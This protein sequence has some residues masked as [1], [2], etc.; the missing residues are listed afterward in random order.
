MSRISRITAAEG[1]KLVQA[2]ADTETALSNRMQESGHETAEVDTAMDALIKWWEDAHATQVGFTATGGYSTADGR[3]AAH[4]TKT[5][6]LAITNRQAAYRE[7]K[8]NSITYDEYKAVLKT[9]RAAGKRARKDQ[10]RQEATNINKLH[11]DK[12]PEGRKKLEHILANVARRGKKRDTPVLPAVHRIQGMSEAGAITTSE[13]E[14]SEVFAAHL[15]SI[16]GKESEA[17]ATERATRGTSRKSMPRRRPPP[18]TIAST[19]WR[20]RIFCDGGAA[21]NPGPTGAG[22]T[23][24]SGPFTT[25]IKIGCERKRT[26]ICTCGIDPTDGT[27]IAQLSMHIAAHGTNNDGEWMAVHRAARYAAEHKLA[28]IDIT[29]DSARVTAQINS[30]ASAHHPKHAAV[31]DA[32]ASLL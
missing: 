23:V 19:R 2:L 10:K 16:G 18:S 7:Y 29:T 9:T 17:T 13:Q 11:L 21:P 28:N 20:Y 3:P 1:E 15:A 25:D 30:N 4:M 12:S 22:I 32:T 14:S 6:L 24:A 8:A 31:H 26:G 5:L 27:M